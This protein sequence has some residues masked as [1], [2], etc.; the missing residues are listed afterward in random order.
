MH[1]Y[2]TDWMI[3]NTYDNLQLFQG[4]EYSTKHG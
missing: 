3:A 1:D 4:N 2:V